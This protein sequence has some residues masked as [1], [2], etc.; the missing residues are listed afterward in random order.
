V[1]PVVRV[2]FIFGGLVCIGVGAMLAAW[3]HV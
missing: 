1:I 3:A 2:G